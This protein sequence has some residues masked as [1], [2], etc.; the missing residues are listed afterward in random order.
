MSCWA[1]V[2]PES[3]FYPIFGDIQV[4][5]LSLVPFTPRG[6]GCPLCYMVLC[7]QLPVEMVD[8]IAQKLFNAWQSECN[9]YEL[10]RNYI[11]KGLPMKTN[12]FQNVFSDDYYQMPVGAALNIAAHLS[13]LS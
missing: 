6:I 1:K 10:A 8:R 4:P 2:K 7:E 12:H 11:L 5:I 9:S 3:E 13:K